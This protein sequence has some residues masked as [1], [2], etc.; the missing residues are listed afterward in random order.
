M[1]NPGRKN[2]RAL[3]QA[4][5]REARR[6][7][8][9]RDKEL[10]E[11][12]GGATSAS[13]WREGGLRAVFVQLPSGN[14]CKAINKGLDAFLK[15]GKIPNALMPII[16]AALAAGEGRPGAKDI[17]EEVLSNP[18]QLDSAFD[19]INIVACE[20]VV[21]PRLVPVPTTVV[22]H[23][24]DKDHAEDWE[25][26]VEIPREERNTEELLAMLGDG[27]WVDETSLDDRMFIMN[28]VV[29]GTR[30]VEQFRGELADVVDDLSAGVEAEQE[31]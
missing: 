23:P 13:E 3:E 2:R 19:L 7:K 12:R 29:G 1:A 6:A 8:Q 25:E 11:R 22:V 10:A 27:L 28:W 9:D 17:G 4:V 18:E 15:A 26:I 31:A 16:S 21:E 24:A 30:D 5:N 14:I 20:C